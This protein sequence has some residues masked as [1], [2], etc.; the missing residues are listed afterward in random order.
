VQ[1]I[2]DEFKNNFS[3]RFRSINKHLM[4]LL[5][6]L[7]CALT[8]SRAALQIAQPVP[9]LELFEAPVYLSQIVVIVVKLA[10]RAC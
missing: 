2:V 9:L 4:S 10:T 6:R 5:Y 1:K 3:L 8:S 7:N